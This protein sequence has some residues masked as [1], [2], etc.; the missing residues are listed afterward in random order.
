MEWPRRWIGDLEWTVEWPGVDGEL[1]DTYK[2][3][4]HNST[5]CTVEYDVQC[6][7]H[8]PTCGQIQFLDNSVIYVG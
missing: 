2:W 8:D 3:T 7:Q 1:D 6:I 4:F 5:F